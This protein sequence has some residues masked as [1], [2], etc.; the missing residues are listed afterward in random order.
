MEVTMEKLKKRLAIIGVFVM[1]LSYNLSHSD[2]SHSYYEILDESED[3]FAK[4]SSGYVYIGNEE[5][6]KDI[7]FVENAILVEDQRFEEDPNMK[8]YSSCDIRSNCARNEILEILQKYE[9]MYPSPW[10]RTIDSMRL[11]WLMHNLSYEFSYQQPRTKH[12]DLDNEDEEVYK[13]KLL[14]KVFHVS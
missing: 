2:Y 7:N 6:L 13:H 11:E 3:A 12:V 8:I 4:C 9:E 1:L 10:D 5:F 14:Q